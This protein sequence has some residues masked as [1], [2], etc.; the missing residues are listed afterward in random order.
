MLTTV[1]I[2][3][4]YN[5]AYSTVIAWIRRGKLKAVKQPNPR[6]DIWV[7]SESALKRFDKER[8]GKGRPKKTAT[9]P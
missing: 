2:A 8:R 5:V 7:V 6:G 9:K 4:R 1:E 3:D